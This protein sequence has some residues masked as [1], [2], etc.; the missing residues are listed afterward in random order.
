MSAVPPFIPR[1]T[2]TAKVLVIGGTGR[3]GGSVVRA[4]REMVP[5]EPPLAGMQPI[6]VVGGRDRGAFLQTRE[7]LMEQDLAA[8]MTEGREFSGEGL[9]GSRGGGDEGGG[10]FVE[11][12]RVQLGGNRPTLKFFEVDATDPSSVAHAIESTS[13]DLVVHT[14]GPFQ[15]STRAAVLEG[16]LR[17]GHKCGY[18]DVCDDYSAAMMAKQMH[19]EAVSKGVTAILSGGIWPGVSNLMALEA[20]ELL[21][22]VDKVESTE[23]SFFTAGSGGAGA[24]LISATFL[25]LAEKALA[26]EKGEAVHYP[27]GSGIRSVDFGESIGSRKVY[28][29]NL[30][31]TE[32]CHHVLGVPNTST[33]FAT[34]PEFWND[35]LRLTTLLPSDILGN[36][37]LMY[38]FSD[39]S[40]PVIRAVDAFVGAANAMRVDA[41]DKNG[42]HA[43]C[44]YGHSD[45]EVCVGEAV[46]SFAIEL[47]LQR[48]TGGPPAVP[49]GVWLPEETCKN[50][51]ALR[52]R[53]VRRSARTAYQYDS[54][55]VKEGERD[56]EREERNRFES[57]SRGI[58]AGR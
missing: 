40:M 23:F 24:T 45:L 39:F 22:G 55:V 1:V 52:E 19:E 3:V 28:R 41:R 48:I 47:L 37:E 5:Q 17:S 51:K 6:I 36:R 35:L 25:I 43:V 42:R 8:M 4:L 14:A 56:G 34:A 30:L 58:M 10:G 13:C 9:F 33:Y 38:S 49:P 2:S 44:L 7:R 27:A 46:A 20:A 50:D 15:R 57:I 21:G 29:I 12:E 54:Y 16:L 53:I 31:E 26:Y 11:G 18:V 32:S